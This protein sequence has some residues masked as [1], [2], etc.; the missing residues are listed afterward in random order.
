MRSKHFRLNLSRSLRR[1]ESLTAVTGLNLSPVGYTNRPEAWIEILKYSI[2]F[3]EVFL[4]PIVVRV[5]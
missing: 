5:V 2:I 4:Y 3:P 1:A